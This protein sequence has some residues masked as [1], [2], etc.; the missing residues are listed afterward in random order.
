MTSKT[1]CNECSGTMQE[2]Y[3]LDAAYGTLLQSK[4]IKGKPEKSFWTGVNT[5]GKTKYYISAYR[6]E[7]CG[8]L[9]LYAEPNNS[10]TNK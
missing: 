1:T 9:K 7:T 6:C 2:G 8:F 4:W 10:E 3:I 5:S